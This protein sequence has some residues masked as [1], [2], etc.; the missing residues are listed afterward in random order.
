ML[1][2]LEQFRRRR[3][4]PA[5]AQSSLARNILCEAV[6]ALKMDSPSKVGIVDAIDPVFWDLVRVSKARH[7]VML[8]HGVTGVLA[9]KT[10]M[11]CICIRHSEGCCSSAAVVESIRSGS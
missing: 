5:R 11:G 4:I 9:S 10:H 8:A 3:S 2:L 1:K 7:R 6:S